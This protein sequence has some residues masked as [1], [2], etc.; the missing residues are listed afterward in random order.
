M[1]AFEFLTELDVRYGAKRHTIGDIY[2]KKNLKVPKASQLAV[3][4][5]ISK[6]IFTWLCAAKLYI[7]SG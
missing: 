1:S 2:G 5:G 6:L 4:S 3:Y 7:S